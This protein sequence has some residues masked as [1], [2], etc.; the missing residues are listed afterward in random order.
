MNKRNS[1]NLRDNNNTN[2]NNINKNINI[3]NMKNIVI[4]RQK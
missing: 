1:L 2:K 4:N 3:K